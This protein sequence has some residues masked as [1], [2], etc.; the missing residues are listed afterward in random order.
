MTDLQFK[1][2]FKRLEDKYPSH[3]KSEDHKSREYADWYSNFIKLENDLTEQAFDYY[4]R[5][6]AQNWFPPLPDMLNCYN[7]MHTEKHSEYKNEEIKRGSIKPLFDGIQ[8]VKERIEAGEVPVGFTDNNFKD[9][10]AF[11]NYKSVSSLSECLVKMFKDTWEAPALA[12]HRRN[13]LAEPKTNRSAKEMLDGVFTV[14]DGSKIKQKLC[15]YCEQ[16]VLK[17]ENG[18]ECPKCEV[19]YA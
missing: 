9:G 18:F 10:G 14:G 3:F 1:I 6:M 15:Y 4:F 11:T 2:H 12:E 17:N 8:A 5:H 7:L 16:R 13:K 19:V